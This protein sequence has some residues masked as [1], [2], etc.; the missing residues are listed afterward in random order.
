MTAQNGKVRILI[1]ARE[2][3][4]RDQ[5]R[6]L[7]ISDGG[8]EVVGTAVDGQEAVQLAVL[9]RPD[10]AL[11]KSDLPI[12]D[13]FEASEMIGLAA[14]EVCN[15]LVGDGQPDSQLLKKA[16]RAGLRAYLPSPVTASDLLETMH[17]LSTIGER[18][19]TSEYR[20]ATDPGRL[21]KIIVVTGGKGGIGKSTMATSLAMCLAKHDPG[22][23]VLFDLYTQFGDIST[24]LNISPVKT[25]SDLVQTETDIDLEMIETHMIEHESGLRVLISSTNTQP[26]DAIS[27]AGAEST[28]Y[29]LKRKYTYIVIDLP[30]ILHATTLYVMSHCYHMFLVTTLFDMPTV[31]D[32]KEFYDTVVGTYVPEENISILANRMSKH[33]RISLAD[34][35]RIFG[36]PVSAHVPNDS[37][38]VSAINQGVPFVKAYAR[39]PLVAAV[40]SIATDLIRQNAASGSKS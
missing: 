16:M 8:Y 27:V 3:G 30:P 15:V 34:V 38:L 1:A 40:D 25:L 7:V 23:V 33:D 36:R 26:I 31:R 29:A 32:A 28:L 13:G 35:E 20:T 39:S 11:I 9:L 21:P 10:I 22:K 14:P 19:T 17:S 5:L 37:R 2:R 12:F 24:M 6:Q 4:L 18:R